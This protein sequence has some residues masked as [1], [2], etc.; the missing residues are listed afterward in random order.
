MKIH[1]TASSLK[2]PDKMLFL[3]S[4]QK[5]YFLKNLCFQVFQNQPLPK[6]IHYSFDWY[7]YLLCIA[8]N[9]PNVHK[10]NIFP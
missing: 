9:N 4:I 10:T 5:Y 3:Q 2:I 6:W 8:E 1:R 7:E